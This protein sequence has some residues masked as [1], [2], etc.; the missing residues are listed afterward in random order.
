MVEQ[1]NSLVT[2]QSSSLHSILVP[3]SYYDVTKWPKFSYSRVTANRSDLI[4]QGGPNQHD[5]CKPHWTTHVNCSHHYHDIWT[6]PAK[7][8]VKGPSHRTPKEPG[9][10][11][12]S[13]NRHHS[14]PRV[15]GR[16]SKYRCKS[17]LQLTG[18]D[19]LLLLSFHTQSNT[20]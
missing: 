12:Q 10:D 9:G 11:I 4:L 5:T 1:R 16:I 2:S 14:T 15:A 6:T 7:T 20:F 19:Y 17:G 3:S 8:R 13:N 18:F